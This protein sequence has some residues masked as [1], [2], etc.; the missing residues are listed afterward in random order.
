MSRVRRLAWAAFG[1]GLA[2]LLV[3]SLAPAD[4][5]PETGLVDKW[6]HLL[7]YALLMTTLGIAAP[8][9]RS[10]VIG[11]AALFVLGIAI[12][13]LQGFVPGRQPSALDVVANTIGLLIGLWLAVVVKRRIV[14][15]WPDPAE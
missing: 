2:I 7:A 8:A 3:S 4:V 15:R 10:H 1:I 11:V 6:E 9:Q 14:A 5:L 13:V 12:E